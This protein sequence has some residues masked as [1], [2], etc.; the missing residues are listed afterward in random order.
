MTT[1]TPTT[2]GSAPGLRRVGLYATLVALALIFLVPLVWMVIT[3]L[4]T[5]TAAQQIPPSWLPNPLAGYG[6]EQILN[7]SANPVLRWFLNSMVAAT[8]HSALVLVTASMAAYSL[9][10]LK[11]RGRGVTFALIVGTLFIPP[12]SLIIPNFLIVDQLNWIDTLAVVVVPGAASAFGVFFLRQFFLSLPNELEEAAT[13]DGANQWQIFYK[14]V[15]PLSRPA[16]AT[17][18]VLSFL[19]NWNDFLWPIFVLFSPENLT[20]PP[21]LGLLQGSYVTDYPVIMAGAVLASLPVLILFVLAQR[22]IIQGVSRS[23]LK[24]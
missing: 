6:Y 11:F 22:H 15:L 21:G 1:P 7:N 16:L 3:S 17:L 19:T 24:G 2:D 23:G 13:L 20:L 10:R 4:K 14:V 8:L 9:A 18:A 5:Y 12:T